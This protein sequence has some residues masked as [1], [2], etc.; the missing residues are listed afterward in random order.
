MKPNDDLRQSHKV[1]SLICRGT[2]GG[3]GR[4]GVEMTDQGPS[5]ST[6]GHQQGKDRR[7]VE[8]EGGPKRLLWSSK[9][10]KSFRDNYI[11]IDD[12]LIRRKIHLS[13]AVV[14]S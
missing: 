4:N 3:V 8:S 1:V 9:Q 12:S 7:S 11:T 13:Y 6:A 10:P 5:G 2:G 14:S